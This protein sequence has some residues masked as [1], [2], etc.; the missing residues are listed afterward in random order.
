MNRYRLSTFSRAQGVLRKNFRLEPTLGSCEKQ[1]SAMR[2]A[3]PG[4]P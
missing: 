2:S 1:R 3:S 4:Q